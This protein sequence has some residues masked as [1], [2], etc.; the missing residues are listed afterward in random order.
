MKNIIINYVQIIITVKIEKEKDCI[1]LLKYVNKYKRINLV[2]WEIYVAILIIMLKCY[3]DLSNIKANS[4]K[5]IQAKL[6]NVNMES[7]AVLLIVYK[8]YRCPWFILYKKIMIFISFT[9]KPSFVLLTNLNMIEVNVNIVII[10]K[11]IEENL[12]IIY[13][14]WKSVQIG[15]EISF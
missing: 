13:I 11:T 12:K 2:N 14:I 7:I 1:I 15:K 3:I 8:K 6:L 4:V 9:S 5:N 10:G